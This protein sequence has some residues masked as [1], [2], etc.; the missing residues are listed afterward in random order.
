MFMITRENLSE[1]LSFDPEGYLT[2]TLYLQIDGAPQA[3]YVIELKDLI[4][5]CKNSLENEKLNPQT[6]ESVN[7]DLKKIQ[8]YVTLEFSKEGVRT[9]VIFSCA[10][11]KWWQVLTLSLP[12][13]NHLEISSKPYIRPLTYLLDKYSRFLCILVE[14]ARARLFEVFAGEI[15]EH[16]DILDEVPGKV[17]MGGFA[18]YEERRIE[19][20]I[21]DHVRRHYK[22][23][24]EAA[25]N[26][27]RK[28]QN[29]HVILGGTEQN[30]NEFRHFL[31]STLQDKLVST[32]LEDINANPKAVLERTMQIEEEIKEDEEKK[33]LQRFLGQVN[34]GGLGVIGL[35]PTLKALQQGQVHSLVVKDGYETHGYRCKNCQSLHSTNGKCQYCDGAVENVGDIVEE[36][37]REALEQGCQV[38]YIT[39]PDADL[40]PSGNIGAILRFKA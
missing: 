3:S 11:K 5:A 8:D 22:H 14:R 23:V 17:K 39:L 2:T 35:D 25:M 32:V 29:D 38:K 20:H 36:A 18:G 27:E 19:R 13:R 6:R 28:Y 40:S 9:L 37:V 34:S 10:A 33:L 15:L 16:T 4:K 1:L 21:E 30:T 7:G 26:L 12:L 24:A 31:H